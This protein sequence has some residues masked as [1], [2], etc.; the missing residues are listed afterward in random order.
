MIRGDRAV[1]HPGGRQHRLLSPLD[2]KGEPVPRAEDAS[3]KHGANRQIDGARYATSL[4]G[5]RLVA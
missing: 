4:L 2:A 1:R 5:V 3:A